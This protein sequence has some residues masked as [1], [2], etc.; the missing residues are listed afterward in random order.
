[1][2]SKDILTEEAIYELNKIKEIKQKLNR[3]DLI[4]KAVKI[5]FS[6]V[7]DNKIF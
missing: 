3:D 4:Y 7:S 1:M 5:W 2:F 6:K